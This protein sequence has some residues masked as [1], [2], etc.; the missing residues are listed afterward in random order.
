MT[1]TGL[2][3]RTKQELVKLLTACYCTV[4]RRQT[5]DCLLR[6]TIEGNDTRSVGMGS[7]A[8]MVYITKVICNQEKGKKE[9]TTPISVNLMRSQVL[10]RAAQ[11][12][13]GIK[14]IWPAPL[15]CDQHILLS[16]ALACRR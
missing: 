13:R 9:K 10:Y 3:K 16:N 2:Q 6:S 8:A 14:P 1:Q 4:T 7:C 12:L 15:F 11:E 5:R